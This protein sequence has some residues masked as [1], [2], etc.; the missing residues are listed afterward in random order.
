M[1]QL[2]AVAHELLIREFQEGFLRDHG[3]PG[4]EIEYVASHD[5]V[6]LRLGGLI[7]WQRVEWP[8]IS[9]SQA[10]ADEA[11]K[12]L[13]SLCQKGKRKVRR[14]PRCYYPRFE[15]DEDA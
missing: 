3:I 8:E 10:V 7:F 4:G 12:C 5:A 1:T 11:I 15:E 14:T 9:T 6:V 13:S 2:E